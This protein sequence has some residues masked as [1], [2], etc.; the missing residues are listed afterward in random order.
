MPKNQISNEPI[1]QPFWLEEYP[2]IFPPTQVAMTEPDG[3]LAVG[4]ALTPEWLLAAYSKGLFPWFSDDE[5]ILWW[6]PNPRSV[7]FV[8]DL[9]IS[10]SLAKLIKQQKFKVTM[11]SAFSEVIKNCAEIKRDDQN[12]TWIIDEMLLAYNNLHQQGHAH[13]V[14]VWQDEKLVGGLYGVAI[15]KVFF[16]ESMFAKT[17]NASKIALVSLVQQL[18]SWGFNLIDTQVETPHLNSL[19]A[20]LI[21]REEFEAILKRD[22]IKDFMIKKWCFD[23]NKH[24]KNPKI[25]RGGAV[26]DPINL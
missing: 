6:T 15:G 25:A 8:D 1:T 16:G 11:D 7:L 3:L 4:G 5:P 12:G 26:I 14:E 13:S 21:S 17:S 24:L 19:G 18:E 9:K 22:S 2:V 20:S 10:K 23:S